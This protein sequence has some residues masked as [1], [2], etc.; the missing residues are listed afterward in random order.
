MP[1]EQLA[2]APSPVLDAY[3]PAAQLEHAEADA[4]EYVPATHE[5]HVVE[6]A[7]EYVPDEQLAHA[8]VPVLGW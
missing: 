8:V 5:R 3:R 2:H 4:A 6:L 7:A 1:T